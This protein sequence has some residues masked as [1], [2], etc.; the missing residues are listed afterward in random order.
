MTLGNYL[1][2]SALSYSINSGRI[3]GKNAAIHALE[4]E[5]GGNKC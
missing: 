1:F 5:R 4:S 3:A 2:G